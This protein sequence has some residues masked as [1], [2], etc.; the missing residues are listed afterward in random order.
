M[1]RTPTPSVPLTPTPTPTLWPSE[2]PVEF[3]LRLQMAATYYRPGDRCWLRARVNN[4]LPVT[5]RRPFFVVLQI[6][7]S[8]WFWPAWD[9]AL[10]YALLDL[11]AG[12]AD[13]PIIAAFDW[14]LTDAALDR[15]AFWAA[16]L[17]EDFQTVLGDE[18][19]LGYWEFGFGP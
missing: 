13:I 6:Q 19:G 8:Y 3:A 17:S 14:P 15:A 2:T 5:G 1:T 7:T 10:D 16:V 11:P 12:A 18:D 4:P 9:T